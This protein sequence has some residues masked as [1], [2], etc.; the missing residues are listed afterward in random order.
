MPGAPNRTNEVCQHSPAL[1][2]LIITGVVKDTNCKPLPFT[3]LDIWQANERGQY[4]EGSSKGSDDFTCRSVIYS[5]ANGVFKFQT[6]FPG[7]YD[8]DGYRPAHIHF[9][10]T[11]KDSQFKPFT[12]QLYFKKDYY[13]YPRDSCGHCNSKDA[14]LVSEVIHLE[15]IKTYVGKWD[16]VLASGDNKLDRVAPQSDSYTQVKSDIMPSKQDIVDKLIK[17][18]KALQNKL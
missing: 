15:D 2:R 4:S 12:T 17:Q 7:R 6:I 10:V 8:D 16:I 14:S 13:L 9:T 3:K 5:D 1:D 18:L 11:A